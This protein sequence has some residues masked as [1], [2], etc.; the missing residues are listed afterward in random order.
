DRDF[1]WGV[2]QDLPEVFLIGRRYEEDRD[3]RA[4]D[5]RWW[6]EQC[7]ALEMPYDAFITWNEPTDVYNDITLELA[8][9]HDDWCCEFR[10]RMVELG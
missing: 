9:R 2:K 8:A 7:A 10:Q 6:A 1:W 4:V 3:W 5:P